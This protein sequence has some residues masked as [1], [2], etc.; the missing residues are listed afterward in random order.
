[1]SNDQITKS[2]YAAGVQCSK[3]LYLLSNQ[4]EAAAAPSED[5]RLRFTQGQTVGQLAHARFLDGHLVSAS[6]SAIQSAIDTTTSLVEDYD[7]SAIFEGAFVY[8]N[9]LIRVD[10]LKNNTDGTWDLIEVKSTTHV[11]KQ[12]LDDVA[13]Q[14]YVLEKN[15][16]KIKNVILSHI[17]KAVRFP[18]LND[19]FIDHDLTEMARD[20]AALIEVNIEKFT[21]VLEQEQ[22][23]ELRIGKQ[24][25]NPYGCEFKKSCWANVPKGST[26]ELYNYR[27]RKP[28]KFDLY[29][30]G[31]KLLQDLT[32][33]VQL[34]RMQQIQVLASKTE[35][36]IMNQPGLLRFLKEVTYPTYYFDFETIAPVVPFLDGMR[37]YQRIPV[38]FS[39]D[40]QYGPGE[41]LVHYEFLASGKPGSDPRRE[42]IRAMKDIFKEA[43]TIIAY[44]D[45][46]EKS[47]IREL[48][49]QFPEDA[50]FLLLHE[51]T[52]WDLEDAFQHHFYHKDFGGSVSIKKVLPY[53]AP[54]MKY[55]DLAI[56]NGGQAQAA[57]FKLLT[58]EHTDEERRQLRQDLL[59]YCAQDSLAMVVIHQKLIQLTNN[60]LRI[61]RPHGERIA[62][63]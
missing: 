3:R 33:E 48:A 47:L 52:F 15:G 61:L 14:L 35:D 27:K 38:Q 17:N 12:H 49:Q 56:Q 9:L 63:L 51:G 21:K 36:P 57:L 62:N 1:M 43:G 39:C 24:C 31:P 58:E 45:D 30:E 26:L 18:N 25:S 37:P 46:F 11:K 32:D 20:E 54:E 53:F 41:E 28:T 6:G 22:A 5:V 40:I 4:R 50:N 16:L 2:K 8:K 44:H 29:H 34:T 60:N 19:F 59:E 42:C 23:P 7:V 13:F 10:I 55:E